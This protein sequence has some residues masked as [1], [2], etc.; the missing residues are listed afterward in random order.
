[1]T[2]RTSLR[3]LS[4]EAG[5]DLEGVRGHLASPDQ[6]AIETIKATVDT[7]GALGMAA[8]VLRT[9]GKILALNTLMDAWRST[10]LVEAGGRCRLADP[11]TCALLQA[12]LAKGV[13]SATIAQPEKGDRPATVIRLLPAAPRDAIPGLADAFILVFSPMVSRTQPDAGLLSSLY[14]LTRGEA[15]VAALAA[16]G[17]GVQAI[18]DWL[19]LSPHTVRTHIRSIHAK[20]GISRHAELVSLL[21]KAPTAP[22]GTYLVG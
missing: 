10:Y 1:M 2:I 3:A 21:A 19:G 5:R 16:Q 15:R 9:N 14:D 6:Q 18:S 11:S 4:D 8:V 13:R 12:S 22:T 20:V 7:L 17:Q